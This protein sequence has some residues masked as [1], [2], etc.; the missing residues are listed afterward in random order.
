MHCKF[1]YIQCFSQGHMS[2]GIPCIYT[3]NLAISRC[4]AL[5][6]AWYIYLLFFSLFVHAVCLITLHDGK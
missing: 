6:V 3:A 5:L 1:T 2:T 4:H